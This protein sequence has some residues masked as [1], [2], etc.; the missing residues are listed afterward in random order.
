MTKQTPTELSPLAIYVHW[1][2]CKS[3]CPYCDFNSHVRESVEYE[4]WQ[5]ALLNEL[6]YMAAKMPDHLVTSIFFGGGTPSLMPPAIAEAIITRVHHHWQTDESVEITLEANPTSVEAGKFSDFRHAGINRVSLGVQS[7]Y[8]DALTFLGREHS[9]GEAL[10]AVELAAATFDRYSF[11]LIYAR[12]NQ[13]PDAWEAELKQALAYAD[14]HLS[15]YQLTIEPNTA[16]HHAYFHKGLFNLPPEDTASELYTLTLDLMKD[17]GLPAYEISNHARNGQ[18]SRHNLS[19]WLGEPYIGIGPGAHGRMWYDD[20]WYAT[21]TIKSPERW[22]DLVQ[23]NGHAIEESVP[24]TADDRAVEYLMMGLRIT[25]GVRLT[26]H[27]LDGIIDTD[28]VTLMIK[29]GLLE[30]TG[31]TLKATRN[32]WMVLNQLIA[33]LLLIENQSVPDQSP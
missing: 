10:K 24:L 7:L 23:K 18:E 9:A 21:S 25:H 8:D 4:H 33:E 20:T 2:F 1:P 12:P 28:K 11:D 5:Q 15:L 17:A 6:N 31:S 22:L 26:Q 13:T 29:E 32:G 16:F 3:K 19:Y 27:G 30:Q 14:G